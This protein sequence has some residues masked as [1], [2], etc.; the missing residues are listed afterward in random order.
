MLVKLQ[1]KQIL[2]IVLVELLLF[3]LF[4]FIVFNFYFSEN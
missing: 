4:T 2:W 1:F 3:D